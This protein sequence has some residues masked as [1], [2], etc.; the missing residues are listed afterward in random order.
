MKEEI[1]I[2]QVFS[3]DLLYVMPY[4]RLWEYNAE[5][6]IFFVFMKLYSLVG[7]IDNNK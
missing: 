7:E 5:E 2:Q 6:D 3:E 4:S 1:L